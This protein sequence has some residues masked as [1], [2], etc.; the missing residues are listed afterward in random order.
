MF[1]VL[2]HFGSFNNDVRRIVDEA[3]E[4]VDTS[5]WTTLKN[6]TNA[7]DSSVAT[8]EKSAREAMEK[9][10]KSFMRLEP[11]IWLLNVHFRKM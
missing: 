8:A 4:N 9:I 1:Y 2:F 6:K 3:I 11:F 7:R 10:G 5:L